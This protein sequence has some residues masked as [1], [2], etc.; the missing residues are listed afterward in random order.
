MTLAREYKLSSYDASYLEL[1]IREG[2][3]IASLDK[4][5]LKA[6]KK[7]NVPIHLKLK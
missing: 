2:L 1:A 3:P 6:A 7:A 4:N 5:L